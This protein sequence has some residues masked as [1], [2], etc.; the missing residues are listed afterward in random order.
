[1]KALQA[2]EIKADH[3]QEW[4]VE[5]QAGVPEAKCTCRFECVRAGEGRGWTMRRQ[6]QLLCRLCYLTD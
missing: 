2:K 1:M 4:E 5:Q 3:K 6:A